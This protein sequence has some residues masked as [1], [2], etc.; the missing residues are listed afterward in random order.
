M[1]R[2]PSVM[3]PDVG[4]SRPATMRSVVVLPQPD[5]PRSAKNDP[6]GTSRSSDF[7]AVNA[8]NSLVRL[9]SRNPAKPS[10]PDS[11][12]ASATCDIGKL[13]FILL[14]LLLVEHHE[15][16]RVLEVFL[17]GEDQWFVDEGVVD[18]HHL[19]A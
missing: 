16:E 1:S 3:V 4:V 11:V 10:T 17:A 15:V 9:R 14:R 8:A 6:V 2:P 18:L 5:G 13:P 7:T 19:V 12:G